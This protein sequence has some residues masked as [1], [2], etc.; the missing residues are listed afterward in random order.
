MNDA[1]TTTIRFCSDRMCFSAGHFTIF[2]SQ[3]RERMHGHN[4]RVEAVITSKLIE[5]GITFDYR[6]YDS[7][8]EALCDS[9]DA[10][11]LLPEKSPYLDIRKE[12]NYYHVK[13]SEDEL[14]F[15]EKDIKFLP[16][17]NITIESLAHW[18]LIQLKE[19][20]SALKSCGVS[21]IQITVYNGPA[22]GATV[23]LKDI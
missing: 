3:H 18:F 10:Y 8:L 2:S 15:L 1:Q 7:K 16:I 9:L 13:F 4:Y 5:P 14:I 17:A 19:D 23:S 20:E 12:G 6:V 22:H 11:F 21:D